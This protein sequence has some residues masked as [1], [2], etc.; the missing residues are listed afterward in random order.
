MLRMN[1]FRENLIFDRLQ[2]G[3][4]TGALSK[5]MSQLSIFAIIYLIVLFFED[6]HYLLL[7]LL[8][9]FGFT[10]HGHWI[11]VGLLIY[12]IFTNYWGAIIPILTFGL[13]G[14]LAAFF[15]FRNIESNLYRTV[16]VD[17]LEGMFDTVIAYY[18]SLI[19]FILAL[20]TSGVLSVVVWALLIFALIYELLRVRTRTSEHWRKLHFPIL[21]RFAKIVGYH[22]G[23]AKSRDEKAK[24]GDMILD[25]LNG[26]LPDW[27]DED[28]DSLIEQ[29]EESIEQFSDK[30]P[31]LEFLEQTHPSASSDDLEKVI[32][33]VSNI[34]SKPENGMRLRYIIAE[35]I[36]LDYGEEE[37]EKYVCNLLTGKID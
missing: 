27:T 19:L 21:I 24:F 36:E 8:L 2:Q 18:F 32:S 33:N 34:L 6:E 30:E 15:G 7:A 3:R 17:A 16:N 13:F 28:I 1:N 26:L 25:F 11:T 22:V 31:L 10:R 37:R 5:F 35:L 23:F 12:C 14:W 4:G 29:A 9:L 20:I